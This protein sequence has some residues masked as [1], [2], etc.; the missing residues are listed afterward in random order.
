ML[1][2]LKHN[3]FIKENDRTYKTSTLTLTHLLAPLD[4]HQSHTLLFC[5]RSNRVHAQDWLVYA[6]MQRG[7]YDGSVAVL[8]DFLLSYNASSSDPFYLPLIYR[9]RGFITIET[10]FWLMYNKKENQQQFVLSIDKIG[11]ATDPSSIEY[12]DD[13][14]SESLIR[15][16]MSFMQQIVRR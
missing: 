15:F 6:Y 16:G 13:L 12:I 5:D 8:N 14:L 10:F 1:C 4:V 2:I 9:A 11:L 3:K 7:R